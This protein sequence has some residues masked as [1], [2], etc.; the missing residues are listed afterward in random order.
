MKRAV[1]IAILSIVVATCFMAAPAFAAELGTGTMAQGTAKAVSTEIKKKAP[2]VK[3]KAHVQ[4]VGWQSWAKNGALAGSKYKGLRLEALKVKLSRVSGS[5][6]YRSHVQNIGWEN[7]WK[8]NGQV[9][10]TKGKGLRVE[11]VQLKLSGAAAKSYN[12]YYRVRCEKLGW[13]GWARNGAYAGTSGLSYR[14]EAVQIKLVKKGAK[15][16]GT[17]SKAFKST[18]GFKSGVPENEKRVLYRAH[19]E[20][21]GWQKLK[22]D[23]QVAGT[24]GE[25]LRMEALRIKLGGA[26]KGS[27]AYRSH[28]QDMGWMAWAQNGRVSGSTGLGLRLEAVQV[29]LQGQA[30]Q[31]YDVYYRVHV[32]NYGWMGWACNGE[33]A[34][35]EGYGLRVEAIQVKLVKKG[36][37]APGPTQGAFEK[38]PLMGQII[39]NIAIA[40]YESGAAAG[41]YHKGGK[42][43]WSTFRKDYEAWCSE[44]AGWCLLQAGCVP[45]ATM[46]GNPT[47]ANSFVRFYNANPQFGTV[48]VNDGSYLPQA[49]DICIHVDS[50]GSPDHTEVC[51]QS[52]ANGYYVDVS[53]NIGGGRV[54][55]REHPFPEWDVGYYITIADL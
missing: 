12:I 2:T 5:V 7:S 14:I 9:S 19:V 6:M 48:H 45:G 42:K 52:C 8:K 43:Y 30:K 31:N 55:T 10:G 11:A 15:A 35:T 26:V 20:N 37:A 4:N 33:E 53:G 29:K 41:D 22:R 49:G 25:G 18:S 17:L 32:Q 13:M 47:Y 36:A 16:P 3:Y 44:F 1:F 46:P 27:I 21:V 34:G 54:L 50:K 28:V 24:S 51:V 39:A 38:K 23:G 40:E